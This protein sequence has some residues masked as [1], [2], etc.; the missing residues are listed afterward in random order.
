LILPN[1]AALS[2]RQCQQLRDF[3]GRGGGLVATH[4]TSL[5]D[6]WGEP[7]A[8]F[9]LADLFGASYAGGIEGP[10]QNSYLAIRR[11]PTTRVF[12]PILEGL[13]DAGRI[14]NGAYRVKVETTDPVKYAPLTLIES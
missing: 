2:D 3:V 5:Y 8:D 10:M 6:E 9:G 1:V 7:R 4:E 12:P 11:D 14:V 13:E